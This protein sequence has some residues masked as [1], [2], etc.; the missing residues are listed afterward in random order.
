M[1]DPAAL[2]KF[3]RA[4]NGVACGN[5]ATRRNPAVSVGHDRPHGIRVLCL[6]DLPNR[7]DRAV[8]HDYFGHEMGADRPG[9]IGSCAPDSAGLR[10]SV[11]VLA[12][13]IHEA[14]FRVRCHHR[15][16]F[17]GIGGI[18]VQVWLRIRCMNQM[19]VHV[20]QLARRRLEGGDAN[21]ECSVHA[22]GHAG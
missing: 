13:G 1:L 7:S 9:E 15:L 18:V 22:G 6:V 20:G 17:G 8:Y 14:D 16:V 5:S 12:G 4:C 2:V 19:L 21:G 11:A 10:V 3:L